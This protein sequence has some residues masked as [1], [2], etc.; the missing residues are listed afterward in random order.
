[1][2]FHLSTVFPG[3]AKG[4]LGWAP[5]GGAILGYLVITG[6]VML[7]MRWVEARL[8]VPGMIARGNA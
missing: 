6:V 4:W 8:R 7:L 1:M 3:A 5:M 2:T